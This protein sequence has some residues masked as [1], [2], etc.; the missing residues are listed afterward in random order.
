MAKIKNFL[1]SWLD[2]VYQTKLIQI[3]LITLSWTIQVESIKLMQLSWTNQV[4]QNFVDSIK[5][6]YIRQSWFVQVDQIKL[7]RSS[8]LDLVD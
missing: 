8:W 2:Y 4:G 1:I 3:K 6:Y 5:F 7:T